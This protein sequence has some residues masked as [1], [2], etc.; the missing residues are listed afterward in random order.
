MTGR[1]WLAAIEVPRDAGAIFLDVLA[2]L[3]ESVSC[4][5]VAGGGA[6]RLEALFDHAPDRTALETRLALAAAA[7]GASPSDLLIAA[8]PKRDWLAENRKQFPPVAAG[9]FFVHGSFFEGRVPPGLIPI[10]LDAGL[11]FGSGT[12]ESTR[13]CLLALDRLARVRRFGKA[14]DLGCGSGILSI[15]IAKRWR[16]RVI[17]ADIDPVAL[18]VTHA[19]ARRNKVASLI[20]AVASAGLKDARLRHARPY[21]L[22]VANILARPLAALAPELSR[23]LAPQGRLVLSGILGAQ[24]AG[25]IAA[26]RAQGLTLVARLTLGDWVTLSLRR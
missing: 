22:I 5:E 7:A 11:A 24:A 2:E 21:A 6:W 26:Y 23:A 13:G 3:A 9:R 25:V 18:G 17:A 15:A 4:F 14:L 12:H 16:A 19:N 1:L 8:L 20:R 10:I